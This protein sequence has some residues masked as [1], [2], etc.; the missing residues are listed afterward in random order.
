M[1]AGNAGIPQQV[2]DKKCHSESTEN[3]KVLKINKNTKINP[4]NTGKHGY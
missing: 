2:E 3:Q 4:E 1:Y